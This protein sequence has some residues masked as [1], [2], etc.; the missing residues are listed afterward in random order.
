V[1]ISLL[2]GFPILGGLS[3]VFSSWGKLTWEAAWWFILGG[4]IAPGF[5][6]LLLFLGIR[7]I[8]VGRAMPLVTTTPFFATLLAAAWLGERPGPA[9]WGATACVVAGCAL[10]SLK[11]AGDADWR[12]IHILYP[13]GHS[14]AL[15]VA[16]ATRR[17]AL[18]LT[19]DPIIGALIAS[20]AS[21]P[22][23]LLSG[24]LLPAQERF[25]VSRPALL[26]FLLM[27]VVNTLGFLLFFAS[28]RYGEV[29]LVVPLGYSAPLFSL[30]F[31]RFWL[32]EEEKVTWNKTAGAL[33]LFLGMAAIVWMAA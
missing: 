9:V 2:V 1:V 16:S 17:H 28:F 15:A 7:H 22:V 14:L 11:P 23:V 30:L 10:L 27:S 13:L 6:R 21:L 20:L 31:A 3:L 19:P 25:R 18:L 24:R 33:L 4:L 32:R 12:R 29:W 8:G 5:G 26:G